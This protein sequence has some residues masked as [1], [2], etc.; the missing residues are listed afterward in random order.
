MKSSPLW[1]YQS[2][3]IHET[4]SAILRQRSTNKSD[5]R[6]VALRDLDLSSAKSILDLGCGFGFMEESLAT[7]VAPDARF[8]GVDAWPANERPFLEKVTANGRT[9]R[10]VCMRLAPELPWPESSCPTGF[11]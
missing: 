11:F 1:P 8:V 3:V 6:E 10:F 5:V 7:R 9:G 4:V 2:P